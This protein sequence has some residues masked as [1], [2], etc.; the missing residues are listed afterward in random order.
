MRRKRII[1]SVTNDLFSDQRV[2]RTCST[3]HESGY[4][5]LLAGRRLKGSPP[6]QKRPY[7]I[8][9]FKL[10]FNRGFLFYAEYNIRLFFFLLFKKTDILFSNDLDTLAANYLTSKLKNKVLIYDSHEYF[11]EMPELTNTFAKRFWLFLEARLLPK[12]KYNITVCD[13][14]A[15]IYQEKYNTVFLTIRNTPRK[16]VPSKEKNKK[17]LGLPEDKSIL[18]LQGGGINKER[19]VEELIEAINYLP[20]VFLI[21]LGGGDQMQ[22]LQNLAKEK[23]K[24]Q[25]IRFI[26]R[27]SYREMMSHT[28]LA[29]LGLALEKANSLNMKYSLPNKVFEYIQ[30]GIPVLSTSLPEKKRLIEKYQ[31]GEL[32]DNLNPQALS[33]Q[34]KE[35]LSNNE[36]RK[37]W[38]KNIANAARILV[39]EEESKKLKSLIRKI[40]EK[41][42]LNG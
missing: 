15:K 38:K 24:S 30:A 33:T 35:M 40:E 16:F 10:L 25:Q 5:V 27:L 28:T 34:I 18:I 29:D 36:K 22:A 26:P 39:W 6:L 42:I 14:I 21:I 3:F 12:I 9:R 37:L 17:D 7:A 13:S 20:D 11:T 4:D 1:I 19:G 8:K 32:I 41:E 23:I 31:V 2:E